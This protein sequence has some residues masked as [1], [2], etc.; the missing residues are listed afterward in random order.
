VLLER[1]HGIDE[2]PWQNLH[3]KP[4]DAY[5]LAR[6]LAGYGVRSKNI[7]DGA[8]VVKGYERASFAE[9]WARYL[10]ALPGTPRAG[11]EDPGPGPDPGASGGS[12]TRGM[13][14]PRAASSLRRNPATSAT[15]ATRPGFESARGPWGVADYPAV[16]DG[17]P[18]QREVSA[19]GFEPAVAPVADVADLSE[20]ENGTDTG[21]NML[22][23]GR[24]GAPTPARAPVGGRGYRWGWCP[25][26]GYVSYVDD[27]PSGATDS[28]SAS[29]SE[30]GSASDVGEGG[31]A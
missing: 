19:T 12:D 23:C 14:A 31:A 17:E 16:A 13:D 30:P 4:L 8:G 26:C 25:T 18:L 5:G 28:D 22:A 3:G 9:A 11:G 27:D 24:C 2:A 21:A 6:R 20:R 29:D 15:S 7:R 1:L 10:P